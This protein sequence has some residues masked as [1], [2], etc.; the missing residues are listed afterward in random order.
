VKTVP[1]IAGSNS[2]ESSSTSKKD[3]RDPKILSGVKI[4]YFDPRFLPKIHLFELV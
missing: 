3:F 4:Q 1:I 2:Q